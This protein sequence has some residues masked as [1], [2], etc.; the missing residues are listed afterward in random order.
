MIPKEGSG[1]PRNESSLSQE[2]NFGA[3]RARRGQRPS[4][5]ADA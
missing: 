1:V 3:I 4:R 5:A 2:G